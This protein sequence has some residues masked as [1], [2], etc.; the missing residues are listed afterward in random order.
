MRGQYFVRKT[1]SDPLIK[2][3]AIL[4]LSDTLN[5]MH[6]HLRIDSSGIIYGAT[7]FT[8]TARVHSTLIAYRHAL[9]TR[10]RTSPRLLVISCSHYTNVV[11]SHYTQCSVLCIVRAFVCQCMAAC[12]YCTKRYPM[13]LS[14]ELH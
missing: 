13:G 4:E 3:D 12:F 7:Y 9:C 5:S 14:D 11:I 2:L 10:M 1:Y 6:F 8:T